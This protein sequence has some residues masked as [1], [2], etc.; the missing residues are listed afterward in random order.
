MIVWGWRSGRSLRHGVEHSCARASP[1]RTQMFWLAATEVTTRQEPVHMKN[2]PVPQQSQTIRLY[3]AI[4]AANGEG[5][6]TTWHSERHSNALSAAEKVA[7]QQTFQSKCHVMFTRGKPFCGVEIVPTFSRSK[8]EILRTSCSPGTAELWQWRTCHKSAHT[9]QAETDSA[10][11]SESWHP[12][13]TGPL[14]ML[15][16]KSVMWGRNPASGCRQHHDSCLCPQGT[17]FALSLSRCVA[18]R[19]QLKSRPHKSCVPAPERGEIALEIAILQHVF[20]IQTLDAECATQQ[21]S[22]APQRLVE[23]GEIR[24]MGAQPSPGTRRPC[25]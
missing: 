8:P 18:C 6:Q 1:P 19:M 10:R 2:A 21:H 23:C 25:L 12:A 22:S 20:G 4:E 24:L 11:F 17:A 15:N 7:L 16:R 5:V 9:S 3:E 14:P 13:A